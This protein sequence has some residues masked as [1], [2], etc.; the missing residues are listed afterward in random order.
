MALAAHL[1]L[2]SGGS[3][4]ITPNVGLMV[5]TLVVFLLSWLVL[6]KW[7]F[8]RIRDALDARANRI[9]ESIDAAEHTRQ[10]AD[11]LLDDYRERL[12]DA[13]SQAD[14][15]IAR[16][17]T[18]AEAHERSASE[19][20]KLKRDQLMEQTR[21]DIEAETRRAIQEIRDEVADLTV[22]A[23]EKVTRKSLDEGDQRRLVEEALGELDFSALSGEVRGE[24]R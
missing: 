13:R 2:A 1:P 18:A 6:R 22:L 10:E 19:E 9:N 15:I 24:G 7:V 14:E 17:R 12:K 3:F 16:A 23:T 5:W 8:P 11:Q 21:R 4:L 20:A